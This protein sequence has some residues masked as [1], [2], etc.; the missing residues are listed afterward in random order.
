MADAKYLLALFIVAIAA[1]LVLLIIRHDRRERLKKSGLAVQLG[2][3]PY[4][5]NNSELEG[6]IVALHTATSRQRLELDHTFIR[7]EGEVKYLLFDLIDT[8]DD[9]SILQEGGLAVISSQLDLPRFSI[10]PKIIEGGRLSDWG[11]RFLQALIERR[12]GLV[13]MN[14]NPRF[15]ERYFLIAPDP[16]P[17][18]VFL[19]TYRL[20]HLSSQSYQ[21][22]EAGGRI[23][24]YARFPFEHAGRDT[25][26]HLREGLA[27]ARN[28]Y[29]IFQTG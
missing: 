2:F 26:Q 22:I 17:V 7:L 1:S 16:V 25:E 27:Q 14:D 18:L 15:D 20:S 12:G 4:D 10:F 3:T 21:S 8:T 6:Q 28:L 11:N 23:F 9:V 24:T 5:K 19:D 29:Q 13:E